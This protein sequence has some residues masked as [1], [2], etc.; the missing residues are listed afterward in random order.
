MRPADL[1]KSI[2]ELKLKASSDLDCRVHGDIDQALAETTR[3]NAVHTEPRLGRYFMKNPMIKLAAAAIIVVAVILGLNPFTKG[4]VT[5]ARVSEY[6]L[7]YGTIALDL[8]P[9]GEA[10]G[11]VMHDV[12]KGNRIR[13]TM[14]NMDIV[15][16]LDLD[17]EKMLHLNPTTKS[18]AYVDIQ[19]TVTEGT[20]ELLNMVRSIVSRVEENPEIVVQKLGRRDFDGVEAVGFQLKEPNVTI[21]LWADPVTATPKRIDIAIGQNRGILKN[22]EFDIP[23]S[24]DLVSMEVPE[25]YTLAQQPMVMGEASEED[26]IVTLELWA[27]Q[28][29]NRIFPDK[30]GVPQLMQL[31]PDLTAALEQMEGSEAEKTALGMHY[32]RTVMF[33]QLLGQQGEWHYAGKDVTFGDS[34]TAVFWYRRGD[35]KTY[36]IIY[37]DLHVE[38]VGLDR[39]PQ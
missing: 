22:I 21:S 29:R 28:V 33:L 31:L 18:A 11:P 14:S 34:E 9:G 5:F 10:S 27:V 4:T 36:R 13:R 1:D 35:T 19:G 3:I 25:G 12:I 24:D 26:L 23:V 7:S 17:S 32:G 39:L 2:K 20:H 6:L 15:M 8:I 16:I 37:G 30:I 38:E